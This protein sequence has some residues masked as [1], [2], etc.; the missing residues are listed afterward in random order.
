MGNWWSTKKA[1]EN[2]VQ[3]CV[4]ALKLGVSV[5][6]LSWVKALCNLGKESR[7]RTESGMSKTSVYTCTFNE[8]AVTLTFTDNI[9]VDGTKSFL[10]EDESNNVWKLNDNG[11]FEELVESSSEISD[12][13]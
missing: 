8:F 6:D 2:S 3:E 1:E 7:R 13:E 4:E 12:T 10:I 9:L 5:D 11:W